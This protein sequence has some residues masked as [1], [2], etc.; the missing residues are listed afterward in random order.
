MGTLRMLYSVILTYIFKVK[1]FKWL[2]RQ[3]KPENVKITNA[4]R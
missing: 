4:V 3:A 1:V 2:F